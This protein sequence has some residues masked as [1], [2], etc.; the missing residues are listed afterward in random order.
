MTSL[1]P[2]HL[3][4]V[5]E[6]IRQ[7]FTA[8]RPNDFLHNFMGRGAPIVYNPPDGRVRHTYLPCEARDVF[9]FYLKPA[10]E[11]H[12]SEPLKFFIEA[13]KRIFAHLV[14]CIFARFLFLP[15]V[16]YCVND[17]KTNE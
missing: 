15:P 3:R 12:N 10:V 14:K 4:Q 9:G 13:M 5:K 17:R 7:H 11:S 1:T 16:Q 6:V 2:Q 8:G